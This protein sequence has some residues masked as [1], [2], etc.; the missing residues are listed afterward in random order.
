MSG[1]VRNLLDRFYQHVDESLL[2]GKNMYFIFQGYAPTKQQL[3][4]G[5]YTMQRFC[6][7]IWNELSW[8]DY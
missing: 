4:A 6:K 1:A 2:K 5:E 3:E 7:F 8:D